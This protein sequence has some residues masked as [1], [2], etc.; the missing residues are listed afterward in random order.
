MHPRVVLHADMDA[1][2]ASIEQRDHPELRGKP[3]AVGGD[4]RRGV[5]SA[6]S[7]EARQFGVHSAMSSVEARRR[8]PELIFVP[9]SM[10]RYAA[11]S[12][13]IFEIFGRFTPA[14]QGL[15][16]DEAFLDLTGTERLWG[17][18]RG[19]A[20]ALRRAV[21]EET[22]LPVSVGIAP[23]KM[24]AKIASDLAK[25]DGLLE[26]APGDV[27]DFLAPLP[28]RR[29]WGVGPVAEQRLLAAGYATIGAL[30]RADP[31][32]LAARFGPWG[33]AL[34]R[35]GQGRDLSE[36]EPYRDA[37]SYSEENTF[38]DD[39]SSPQVLEAALITHA[40]SVAQRL[41]RDRLRARTV[42]LKLKL[43]RRVAPG[44]LPVPTD[45]GALLAHTAT[46]LLARAAL[47]EPVRLLG[48]GVTQ[49]ISADTGQLALFPTRGDR[50]ERLN[51]ALDAIA[52]HFG[53]GAIV[54]GDARPAA[55]AGLSLQR[56]RGAD[57]VDR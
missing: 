19:V 14:V 56:K 31:R 27:A 47:R 11:E 35:L 6:A 32:A 40:E 3:V 46:R 43:A 13:R 50:R 45:D 54:R 9:G 33:V 49:L 4:G 7:Y 41:R 5:V 24:V 25:P 20:L 51:R 8:C 57:P 36:V 44:P 12:K 30:V 21:R 28:V 42:V 23:V 16:L 38:A 2:Y 22:Q 18:A 15:S 53:S 37:V 34:A 55:R 52:D 26:V 48:V 29:I 10:R 39:V 17:P 1:F